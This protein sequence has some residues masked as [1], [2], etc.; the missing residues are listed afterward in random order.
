MGQL[1]PSPSEVHYMPGGYSRMRLVRDAVER[2]L[3]RSN[4]AV[5]LGQTRREVW[6]SVLSSDIKWD[7]IKAVLGNAS[8]VGVT[9]VVVDD[10]VVPDEL[11]PT[12][13]PAFLA[14]ITVTV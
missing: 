11:A 3:A 7:V 2:D 9:A 13:L 12:R 8:P 14:G 10:H 6:V 4:L 1:W 5:T